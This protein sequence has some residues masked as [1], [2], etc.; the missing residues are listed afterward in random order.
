MMNDKGAKGIVPQGAPV[1]D[2][3]EVPLLEFI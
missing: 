2:A 3:L 1:L